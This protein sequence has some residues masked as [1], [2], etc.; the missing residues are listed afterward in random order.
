MANNCPKCGNPIRPSGKFCGSCG[1]NIVSA[2]PTPP[3]APQSATP[4]PAAV[5]TPTPYPAHLHT[6]A[7]A[8]AGIVCP[9][10]GKPTRLGVKFCASCGKTIASTP[11][12][13]PFTPAPMTQSDIT[14][15]PRIVTIG[16]LVGVI[17][18][19]CVSIVVIAWGV[20]VTDLVLDM[21]PTPTPDTPTG[22]LHFLDSL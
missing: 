8:P 14:R 13:P 16:F 11:P 1:F 7:P 10:C 15:K 21:F 22:L 18:L 17:L 6:P 3:P 5:P 12:P 9:H 19:I 20:G 2:T 4:P